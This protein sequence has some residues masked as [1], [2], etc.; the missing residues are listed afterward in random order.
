MP[1]F[2]SIFFLLFHLFFLVPVAFAQSATALDWKGTINKKIHFSMWTDIYDIESGLVVGEVQY[3]KGRAPIFLIGNWTENNRNF[4]LKEM[5]SDG[6]ISGIFEGDVEN[7]LF[8]GKWHSLGKVIRKDGQFNYKEGSNYSFEAFEQ[9]QGYETY[10]WVLDADKVAGTYR[11]N[12]GEYQGEG[13]LVV[14][15]DSDKRLAFQISS[16]TRAPSFN[17][18]QLPSSD[19]GESN[20]AYGRLNG[21]Q[22]LYEVNQDCAITIDFY[23]DFAQV[24]YVK[25]RYC[26]GY[27]GMGATVSGDFLK[28]KSSKKGR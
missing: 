6:T 3:A 8:K 23:N 2:K 12:Y 28:I 4:Y 7:G 21:N 5:L 26:Q 15:K 24:Q 18:A 27:F 14:R 11:Y 16:V 1:S 10:D 25:N 22:L 20:W 19:S 17:M 13:T 9:G